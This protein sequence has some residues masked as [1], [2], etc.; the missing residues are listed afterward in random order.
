MN[1]YDIIDEKYFKEIIIEMAHHSTAIEGNTLS[2]SET[3]TLLTEDSIDIKRKVALRD[4]F[5]VS[6]YK[7]II[8][9]LHRDY[10][11]TVETIKTFHSILTN[12]TLYNPGQFKTEENTVGGKLTT[13]PSKVREEIYNWV[14]N[15]KFRLNIAKNND[16][17]L[18]I[19]ADSH[20]QFENIHPFTDG[21]GRTGRL[22]MIFLA[23]KE[24]IIPF[25]IQKDDRNEYINYLKNEDAKGLK[26]YLYR[27]QEKEIN[28]VEEIYGIKISDEINWSKKENNIEIKR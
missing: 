15:T 21:N 11:F 19:I 27:L 25:I 18:D 22:L 12:N 4:I 20:I 16:E 9:Y 24:N 8:F 28:R 1:F 14:E 6:N 2:L 7:N 23:I 13:H 10:P 17:K 3:R 5:E 26:E